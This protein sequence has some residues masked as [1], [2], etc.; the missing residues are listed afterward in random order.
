MEFFRSGIV[1]FF[2]CLLVDKRA[3]EFLPA[4]FFDVSNPF[5]APAIPGNAFICRRGGSGSAAVGIVLPDSA[6]AF[7]DNTCES[8]MMC[9]TA[10]HRLTE[11]RVTVALCQHSKKKWLF[12]VFARL[13]LRFLRENSLILP[14]YC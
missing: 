11:W 2:R 13:R 1:S 14:E 10:K 7:F 12:D 5:P 3:E 8:G 6:V 4:V 9:R